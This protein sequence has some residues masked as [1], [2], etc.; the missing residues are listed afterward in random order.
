MKLDTRQKSIIRNLVKDDFA[1]TVV[2]V[3]MGDFENNTSALSYNHFALAIREAK[4]HDIGVRAPDEKVSKYAWAKEKAKKGKLPR[5]FKLRYLIQRN[6]PDRYIKSMDRVISKIKELDEKLDDLNNYVHLTEDTFGCTDDKIRNE[7]SAF[8]EAVDS[9][10]NL[11]QDIIKC[12]R[13]EL[14]D[15]ID[16]EFYK[17]YLFNGL[18]KIEVLAPHVYLE[19]VD[20]EITQMEI[21][22]DRIEIEVN[23]SISCKLIHGSMHEYEEDD[24]IGTDDSCPFSWNLYIP[25]DGEFKLQADEEPDVDTDA[26]YE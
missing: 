14:L 10:N 15:N 1:K 24:E 6:I 16:D 17:N 18:K 4:N 9:Y 2:D 13:E 7:I 5:V 22:D 23:G 25:L 20:Y 3:A 26:F 12:L 21:C 19:D 8:I 11:E